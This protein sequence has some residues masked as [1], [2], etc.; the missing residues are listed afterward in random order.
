LEGFSREEIKSI[1][2]VSQTFITTGLQRYRDGG[3][4]NLKQQYKGTVGYLSCEEKEDVKKYLNEKD[5]WDLDGLK[6]Y[7]R[8]AY[9]VEYKSDQSYYEI[10]ENAGIS[11]KKTQKKNPKKD[12]KEVLKKRKG[13]KKN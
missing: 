6:K 3:V 1:L 5:V 9:G 12:E 11:W 13:I 7:L 4:E 8:E 2:Q 10:F